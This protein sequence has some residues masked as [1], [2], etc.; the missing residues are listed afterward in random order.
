MRPVIRKLTPGSILNSDP[1][2]PYSGQ[3]THGTGKGAI[4]LM[5]VA[6]DNEG[7]ETSLTREVAARDL[8]RQSTNSDEH[9]QGVGAGYSNHH[10]IISGRSE[11][12][13]LKGVSGRGGI[14]V[15]HE[16]MVVYEPA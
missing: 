3:G 12:A 5:S 4:K 8:E 6:R 15:K 16:M 1:S 7:D 11:A 14:H 10:T 2:Q 13:S 9:G